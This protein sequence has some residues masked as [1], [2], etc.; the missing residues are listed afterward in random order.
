MTLL[1]PFTMTIPLFLKSRVYLHKIPGIESIPHDGEK[2]G[3]AAAAIG[4]ESKVPVDHSGRNPQ[5]RV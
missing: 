2:Q 4:L 1:S 5:F 3:H